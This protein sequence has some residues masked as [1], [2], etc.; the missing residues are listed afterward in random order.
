MI[1]SNGMK[2]NKDVIGGFLCSL[3]WAL[4]FPKNEAKFKIRQRS[5]KRNCRDVR[6]ESMPYKRRTET[7]SV[8]L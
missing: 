6:F 2:L 4:V 1:D 8:K 7:S 5:I 3:W